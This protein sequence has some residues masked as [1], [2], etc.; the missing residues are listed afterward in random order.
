ML[1]TV[2]TAASGVNGREAIVAI[3]GGTMLTLALTRPR[4]RWVE[5]VTK[6]SDA[7]RAWCERA[8]TFFSLVMAGYAATTLLDALHKQLGA[9]AD[10]LLEGAGMF[11]FA[12]A[13]LVHFEPFVREWRLRGGSGAAGLYT[14]VLGAAVIIGGLLSE[15]ALRPSFPLADAAFVPTALVPVALGWGAYRWGPDFGLPTRRPTQEGTS[16]QDP[17]EL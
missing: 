14:G 8:L 11:L 7:G 4:L 3:V 16:A 6:D 1:A 13:W 5:N 15:V 12:Y 9:E 2:R 17:E 10:S